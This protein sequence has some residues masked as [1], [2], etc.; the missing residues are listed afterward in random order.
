MSKK[1]RNVEEKDSTS[2]SEGE[3]DKNIH[4]VPTFIVSKE[5]QE[6]GRIVETPIEKLED[7]LFNNLIGD[8]PKPNYEEWGTGGK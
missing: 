6:I 8:P 4:H 2:S 3:K 1:S 5:R 7:D